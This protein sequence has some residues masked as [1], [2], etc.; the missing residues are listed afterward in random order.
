MATKEKVVRYISRYIQLRIVRKPGYSKEVDGQRVSTPGTSIQFDQ[1]VFETSDPDEVAFIEARPEFGKLIQRVPDNV[2]NLSKERQE[3]FQSLEEREAAIAAR[4]AAV[5]KKEAQLTGGE[6]GRA[7]GDGVDE[8]EGDDLDEYTKAG[9]L[10]IVEKEAVEGVTSR[11]KVVDIL[12][13]IRSKRKAV[14]DEA[15]AF[16]E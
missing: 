8:E 9:L 15:A 1:G 12:A 7:E 16:D 6:S 4:E 3:Q 5:A 2:E 13:A 10:E 11:S 14:A